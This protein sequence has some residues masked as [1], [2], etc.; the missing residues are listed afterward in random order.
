MFRNKV[1]LTRDRYKNNCNRM[2]N[3]I[4]KSSFLS[5]F[6]N[7]VLNIEEIKELY[8]SKMVLFVSNQYNKEHIALSL[9]QIISFSNRETSDNLDEL[10]KIS[11]EILPGYLEY[12]GDY[13][14]NYNDSI[15]YRLKFM[16][17]IVI[18]E[19]TILDEIVLDNIDNLD[20][21]F[22]YSLD[23]GLFERFN[24]TDYHCYN[25][26]SYN[27]TKVEIAY[28][29]YANQFFDKED[30]FTR[31]IEK[32]RNNLDNRGKRYLNI[33]TN[34][35][36]NSQTVDKFIFSNER[37]K[38]VSNSKDKYDIV[39]TYLEFVDRVQD[40]KLEDEFSEMS[41]DKPVNEI[42]YIRKTIPKTVRN[43]L[44]REYNGSS[45]DGICFCCKN[46]LKYENFHVGH[47]IPVCKGGTDNKTN[48]RPLCASCNTSMGS[49]NLFE[50]I[51]QYL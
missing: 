22:V 25:F 45:M 28:E 19:I 38:M 27:K 35:F 2:K 16:H 42:K 43:L 37:Y 5:Y 11:W 49:Q 9:K 40:V 31:S 1:N 10:F 51:E 20:D 48:L 50:F 33:D 15:A 6:I 7:K 32:I 14:L 23:T 17:K 4:Y 41:L 39:F 18:N 47:V 8:G 46:G 21:K 34:K 36:I 29:M 12:F 44:W 3:E 30:D 24:N 13:Y 26:Q